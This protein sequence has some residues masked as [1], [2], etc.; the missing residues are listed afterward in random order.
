AVIRAWKCYGYD[1]ID[2]PLASVA[3]RVAFVRRHL[4]GVRA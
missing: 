2:L 3:D 1:P 4:E